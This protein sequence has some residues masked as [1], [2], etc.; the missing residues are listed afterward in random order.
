MIPNCLA[1]KDPRSPEVRKRYEEG[2]V[3]VIWMGKNG[4]PRMGTLLSSWFLYC[5]VISIV[6]AYVAGHVLLRSAPHLEVFR[7]VGTMAFLAYAC[8]HW[9]NTIWKAKPV[10]ISVKETLDGLIYGLATGAAFTWLWP[11]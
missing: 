6:V 9:S 2:P 7:I 4:F 8:A 3:A 1:E 5:I 11:S 10:I